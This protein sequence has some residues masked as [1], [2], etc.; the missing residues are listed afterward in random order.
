MVS[1]AG[2][3]SALDLAP[4]NFERATAL[5]SR[6][7]EDYMP[8]L[9]SGQTALLFA[10]PTSQVRQCHAVP[11]TPAEFSQADDGGTQLLLGR[12]KR[13]HGVG[14]DAVP[15]LRVT[16][17]LSVGRAKQRCFGDNCRAPAASYLRG[18]K[19]RLSAMA[20]AHGY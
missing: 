16:V 13:E 14:A 5:L 2:F 9:T 19:S 15:G 10:D 4:D 1:E 17:N 6:T 20:S 3:L 7:R 11:D 12:K 18:G 8:T